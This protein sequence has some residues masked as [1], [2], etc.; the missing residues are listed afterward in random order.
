MQVLRTVFVSANLEAIGG[1]NAIRTIRS[2]D[3]DKSIK[4]VMVS[5]QASQILKIE[6][7]QAGAD[8]YATMPLTVE[9]LKK[10]L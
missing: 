9:H 7:K 6:A 4:V 5:D 10:F 2:M 8:Y 3:P 1:I